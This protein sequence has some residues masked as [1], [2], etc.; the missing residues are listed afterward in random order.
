MKWDFFDLGE[1]RAGGG[2]L[3]AGMGGQQRRALSTI[4]RNII[5]A[6]PYPCVVHKRGA[7]AE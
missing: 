5:G 4:N 7:L 1:L 3:N 2:K 6:P